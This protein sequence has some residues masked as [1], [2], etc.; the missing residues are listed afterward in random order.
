MQ[1]QAYLRSPENF[2]DTVMNIFSINVRLA[3]SWC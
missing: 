2:L 3:Y 1:V